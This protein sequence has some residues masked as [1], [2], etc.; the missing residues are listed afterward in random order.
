LQ[1]DLSVSYEKIGD[2]QKEQG[3][4]EGA[5]KSYNASL[6][7]RGSLAKSN[8]GKAL[9]QRDLSVSYAKIGTVQMATGDLA[10]A[11]KSYSD[12]LDI[13]NPLAKSDRGNA[14]WQLGLFCKIRRATLPGHRGNAQHDLA[15]CFGMLASVHRQ[16]GD[17]AKAL[18][19][20][21]QG[22]AIMSRL[23]NLSPDNAV[24]TKDLAWFDGQIAELAER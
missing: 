12:S 24:W 15:E 7:I 8:R 5:L 23:T 20:L 21:R 13:R 19:A 10:G 6:A 3:D 1:R 14:G 2:V 16:S 4:L 9:L 22:Q 17:S 18:E 11:L